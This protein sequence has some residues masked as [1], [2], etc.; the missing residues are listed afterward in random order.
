MSFHAH[1][2]VWVT[3]NERDALVRISAAV[4]QMEVATMDAIGQFGLLHWRFV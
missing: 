4:V 1:G 3:V 2:Q